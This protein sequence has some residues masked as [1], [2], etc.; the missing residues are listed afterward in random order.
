MPQPARRRVVRSTIRPPGICRRPP[1]ARAVPLA[2]MGCPQEPAQSIR[3]KAAM[4]IRPTRAWEPIPVPLPA[5]RRANR[6]A[7]PLLDLEQPAPRGRLL[8]FDRQKRQLINC[9]NCYNERMFRFSPYSTLI[10]ILI[11]KNN[12]KCPMR[13][14]SAAFNAHLEAQSF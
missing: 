1:E 10:G 4:P 11:Q 8:C 7:I 6:S 14:K 13:E 5:V 12:S 3:Q 9:A 2:R